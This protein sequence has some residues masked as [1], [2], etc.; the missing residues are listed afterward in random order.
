MTRRKRV[1][2]SAELEA[3]RA[4]L[5]LS[6]LAMGRAMGMK[7]PG[8]YRRYARG[9]RQPSLARLSRARRLLKQ[10]SP[11]VAPQDDGAADV[12]TDVDTG[13]NGRPLT[14]ADRLL[15]LARQGWIQ[16]K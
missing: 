4:Q 12:L 11:D 5:G 3:I 6:K 7:Y 2:T 10:A 1:D 8:E 14:E 13:P 9:E 16:V 15:R